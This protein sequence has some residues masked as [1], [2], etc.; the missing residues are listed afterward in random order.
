MNAPHDADNH[1][2]PGVRIAVA[3]FG[4]QAQEFT[5]SDCRSINDV[6]FIRWPDW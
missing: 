1:K 2:P 6:L 4:G 5:N 3:A